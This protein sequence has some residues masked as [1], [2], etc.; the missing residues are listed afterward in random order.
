MLPKGWLRRKRAPVPKPSADFYARLS[1]TTA[2]AMR[3]LTSIDQIAL[4]ARQH[5]VHYAA[6]CA[7]MNVRAATS[8]P[9]RLY[10]PAGPSRKQRR[11]GKSRMRELASG[12]YG[13]KAAAFSDSSSDAVVIDEHPVIDLLET[14][15]QY[16]RSGTRFRAT[17]L[18]DWQVMGK[19][20][21]LLGRSGEGPPDALYH[22][23]P[24]HVVMTRDEKHFIAGYRY[25]RD[26]VKMGD[27][28]V[29]DV[30]YLRYMTHPSDPFDA[31]GPLQMVIPDIE[32]ISRSLVSELNRWDRDARPEVHYEMP[33]GVT[34]EE[35]SLFESALRNVTGAGRRRNYT[36]GPCKPS[37]VGF[38]PKDM[39]YTNGQSLSMRRI[40]NAFGLPESLMELNAA[41]LA[42]ALTGNRQYIETTILPML[43]MYCD[44]LNEE[45]VPL[46]AEPG[47]VWFA[48][49]NPMREDRESIQRIATARV[50]SGE[51]TVNEARNMHGEPPIQGGDELRS[52]AAAM[53]RPDVR[54]PDARDAASKASRVFA[55]KAKPEPWSIAGLAQMIHEWMRDHGARYGPEAVD[56]LAA[57]ME[58]DVRGAFGAGAAAGAGEVAFEGGV[59]AAPSPSLIIAATRGAAASVIESLEQVVSDAVARG[60]TIPQATEEIEALGL[61]YAER[62]ARTELS[63][64]YNVGKDA[65]YASS[66]LR[67]VKEWLLSPDPCEVCL[68][69][70]EAYNGAA[71]SP[72]GVLYPTGSVVQVNGRSV[73]MVRDLIGPPAHPNCRCGMAARVLP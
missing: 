12:A 29:D 2:D 34:R 3:G 42:S 9:I 48:P 1:T 21:W 58:R 61:D 16:E 40:R 49:D 25:G 37:I 43:S 67:L 72:N 54:I 63:A 44:I 10:G 11:V 51:I 28:A 32:L 24:E 36:Y 18:M 68:A 45:L 8:I 22:L 46:F 65:S 14:P 71:L 41:N 13:V 38:A 73:K 27:I 33:E 50:Q 47:E 17:T 15:N 60:L 57:A 59:S 70:A 66:G 5:L 52:S 56:S 30:V 23:L 4:D 64:A 39:E 6:I 19:S 26:G 20:Y 69:L 55:A 31:I 53:L 7:S 35:L 62:I